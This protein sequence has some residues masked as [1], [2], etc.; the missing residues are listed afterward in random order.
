MIQVFRFRPLYTRPAT[1]G[2]VVGFLGLTAAKA[3]V[4]GTST[5]NLFIGLGIIA[6]MM[7]LFYTIR[8]ISRIGRSIDLTPDSII[9]FGKQY[10]LSDLKDLRDEFPK[11]KSK[12]EDKDITC[13][14]ITVF[15]R[16]AK[17]AETSYTLDRKI[18]GFKELR[19]QL[20]KHLS[21]KQEQENQAYEERMSQRLQENPAALHP[22]AKK[23]LARCI[24]C[25]AKVPVIHTDCPH[26]GGSL[27]KRESS[28][29]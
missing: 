2:T 18:Q 5:D 12:I 28:A 21:V 7:A 6:V 17:G 4:K 16:T 25:Y 10:A 11:G 1:L 8:E 27:Q 29:S 22:T 26:C 24:K 13:H 15:F 9:V 19:E 20:V 14:S 3:L 23:E